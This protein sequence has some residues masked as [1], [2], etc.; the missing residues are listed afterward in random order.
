MPDALARTRSLACETK[1]HTSTVTTG[2]AIDRHSLRDGLTAYTRSP[3]STGLVSL[4]SPQVITCALDPSVGGS[5]PR[6]FAARAG[7]VVGAAK[8]AF[9]TH[10]SSH[11]A[12]HVRDDRDTPLRWRRDGA[13]MIIVL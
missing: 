5:G 12:S 7:A 2:P 11:P 1:K 9:S 4:R 3:R 8:R 10:T 13:E 6:D